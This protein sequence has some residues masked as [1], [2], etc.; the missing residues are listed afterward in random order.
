MENV[1]TLVTDR[2]VRAA[3]CCSEGWPWRS[4]GGLPAAP[5]AR[6]RGHA[7]CL[8][9]SERQPG[10]SPVGA[11]ASATRPASEGQGQGTTSPSAGPGCDFELWPRGSAIAA[12]GTRARDTFETKVLISLNERPRS[13]VQLSKYMWG[14][15][16]S[17]YL[18]I[19]SFSLLFS[20]CALFL[21]FKGCNA[22]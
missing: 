20:P 9:A 7:V 15:F 5:R 18:P 10:H 12:E 3:A 19:T 22:F 13:W 17:K 21:A 4:W 14:F 11:R 2:K 1:P 16:Y 8:A 6:L